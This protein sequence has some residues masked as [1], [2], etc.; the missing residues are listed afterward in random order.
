M[1]GFLAIVLPVAAVVAYFAFFAKK[2][3]TPP[4]EVPV[5][6][7][8][9]DL[10]ENDISIRDEPQ[11]GDVWRLNNGDNP[12]AEIVDAEIVDV[13]PGWVRFQY[14]PHGGLWPDTVDSFMRHYSKVS[15]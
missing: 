11:V 14:S 13:A 5:D 1:W 15:P 10:P 4:G 2:R 9:D 3:P 12:W 8:E 7:V 6:Y